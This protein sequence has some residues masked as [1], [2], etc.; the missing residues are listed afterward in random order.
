[1]PDQI[2][3]LY[4]VQLQNQIVEA[5]SVSGR[6]SPLFVDLLGALVAVDSE[7]CADVQSWL[8]KR[9]VRLVAMAVKLL[10]E[11]YSRRLASAARRARQKADGA[12]DADAVARELVHDVWPNIRNAANAQARRDPQKAGLIL[13]LVEVVI[14]GVPH[15]ATKDSATQGLFQVRNIRMSP[16]AR[17]QVH[18]K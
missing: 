4:T 7:A 15:M 1:L 12:E 17:I 5:C 2:R 13:S 3:F 8:R 9:S 18:S 16:S 14:S 10:R 11:A 6:A